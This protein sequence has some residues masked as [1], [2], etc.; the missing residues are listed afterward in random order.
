MSIKTRHITITD[1]KLWDENARFPNKYFNSEE[2]DLI[3]YFLSKPDFKIKLLVEAIINDIDLPQ[4]EK[5]VVWH[6]N[7]QNI[8]LEGNRRLT[9]YKLLNNPELTSDSKLKKY[10]V[11]Q[12]RKTN[13]SNNFLLECL[14]TEDK[15]T[16]YRYIDRKHA[17][18]NYEVNWKDA[19]RAHY[20]VR[21]GSKIQNELL[22]IGITKIVKELD[23]PDEM[24][25]QILGSGY[26]TT[27][28][29]IITSTP[30]KNK[31]GYEIDKEGNF[32]V[33]DPNFNEKLK[34][35]IYNVLNKKDFK[36]KDVD[37][38]SLN[39]IDKIKEYIESVKIEDVPKVDEE[40]RKNTTENIFGESSLIIDNANN[41]SIGKS[42]NLKSKP[43]PTG[44]FFSSDV[45]FRVGNS[46]LRILYN[47]LRDIN[48]ATFP[49]ASQ[50]LLRSFLECS[51]IVFFKKTND[52]SKILKNDKHNPTLGEMLTYIINGN[53]TSITDK[54]LIDTINQIKTDYNKAYSLARLHMINHNE[55]WI[56]VEKDVRATWAKLEEL[57]K[58]L[59]G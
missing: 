9:A 19:E 32:T 56:A 44:L 11:E 42:S 38:R 50:D 37:S 21:R 22:K 40:I 8:V 39:K 52:Y 6:D 2:S 57:F 33:E 46:N 48:V 12:K 16:G 58:I 14:V 54:N 5:L 43:N 18:S 34:V 41:K 29:R 59:L 3:N 7:G 55:N 17:N 13:I 27:F 1:L 24:K 20:N 53:S 28:F 10:F 45:P 35:I 25:D 31:Y 4:L 26:V 51:L 49:N 30:S 15:E 36:G 23:L 47:E